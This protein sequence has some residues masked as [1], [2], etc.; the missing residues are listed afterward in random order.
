MGWW[1]SGKVGRNGRWGGVRM[2]MEMGRSGEAGIVEEVV[3]AHSS[4]TS[5]IPSKKSFSYVQKTLNWFDIFH[6]VV[7]W[8]LGNHVFEP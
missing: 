7:R 8:S 1:Q 2:G 5:I 6:N 4:Q 3:R